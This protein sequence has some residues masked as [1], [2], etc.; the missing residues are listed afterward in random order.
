MDDCFATSMS[1]V[2]IDTL[3]KFEGTIR[4]FYQSTE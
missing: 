4:H 2:L 3:L 1:F